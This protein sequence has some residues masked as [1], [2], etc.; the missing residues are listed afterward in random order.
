MSDWKWTQIA[1]HDTLTEGPVWDDLEI[2]V[3]TTRTSAM[4]ARM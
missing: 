2:S 1:N 3:R 4:R